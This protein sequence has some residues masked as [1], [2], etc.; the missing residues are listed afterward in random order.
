MVRG[1]QRARPLLVAITQR[2]LAQLLARLDRTT[3]AREFAQEAR[4]TC[5]R[6]RADQEIKKLDALVATLAVPTR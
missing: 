6:L 1:A 3:E 2:D 5:E 4:A